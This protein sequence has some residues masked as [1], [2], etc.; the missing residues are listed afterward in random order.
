MLPKDALIIDFLRIS[1]IYLGKDPGLPA[2]ER[3]LKEIR[4]ENAGQTRSRK[5]WSAYRSI[6]SKPV[7]CGFDPL[8]RT[9]MLRNYKDL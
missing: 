7:G 8:V 9:S 2:I 4:E 3:I 5:G 6:M 1:A